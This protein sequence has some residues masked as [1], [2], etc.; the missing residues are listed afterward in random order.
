MRWNYQSCD[1]KSIPII[2]LSRGGCE[3]SVVL[4]VRN[5]IIASVLSPS[6]S[7]CDIPVKE[8]TSEDSYYRPIFKETHNETSSFLTLMV[9][10]LAPPCILV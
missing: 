4:K 2:S 8:A 9:L 5:K 10:F 3:A 7:L 1:R 6:N